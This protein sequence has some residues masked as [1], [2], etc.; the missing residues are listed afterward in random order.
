MSQPSGSGKS[1]LLRL[2]YRLNDPQE[3]QAR[4]K[5][6]WPCNAGNEI[7]SGWRRC[8]WQYLTWWTPSKPQ[9]PQVFCC[10][11][12]VGCQIQISFQAPAG[13]PHTIAGWS[14]Y[15]I[16]VFTRTMQWQCLVSYRN[17]RVIQGMFYQ[18]SPRMLQ[19]QW[20]IILKSTVRNQAAHLEP[21]QSEPFA[22]QEPF[23]PPRCSLMGRM[24]RHSIHPFDA[25]WASSH[26]CDGEFRE[27]VRK[28]AQYVSKGDRSGW[29]LQSNWCCLFFF[30]PFVTCPVDILFVVLV[31]CMSSLLGLVH[32][33]VF[34]LPRD[35]QLD[36]T[37]VSRNTCSGMHWMLASCLQALLFATEDNCWA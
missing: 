15:L 2:L 1:T 6:T 30:H 17:A 32:T 27:C 20:R 28:E 35:G 4:R 19:F 7:M 25:S 13:R 34:L 5:T 3:G 24:W 18:Q 9:S 29:G 12:S 14:H 36:W 26:R 11:K 8:S 22:Q 10:P 33:A 37:F 16:D 31:I 21:L 23:A